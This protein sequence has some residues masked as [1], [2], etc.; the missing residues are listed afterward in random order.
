MGE[1]KTIEREYT[2]CICGIKFVSLSR[3]NKPS[4]ACCGYECYQIRDKIRRDRKDKLKG[5]LRGGSGKVQAA[6]TSGGTR[7]WIR[8]LP[9]LRSELTTLNASTP[10]EWVCQTRKDIL[11]KWLQRFGVTRMRIEKIGERR[12]YAQNKD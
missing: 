1:H 6:Q 12:G 3:C 10:R 5:L 2:C 8:R 7:L 11:T 9:N 4:V